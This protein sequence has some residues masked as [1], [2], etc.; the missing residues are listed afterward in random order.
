[1]LP[2]SA[3]KPELPWRLAAEVFQLRLSWKQ[4]ASCMKV[5]HGC[6]GRRTRWRPRCVLISTVPYPWHLVRRCLSASSTP[7]SG[8]TK[9]VRWGADLSVSSLVHALRCQ[10]T[11]TLREF[12]DIFDISYIEATLV[13]GWRH[14]R[15]V[16][17]HREH[18]RWFS[19][20]VLDWP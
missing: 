13:P 11:H 16:A 20:A 1:M 9:V 6:A 14:G 10:V 8:P 3:F 19:V 4:H 2:Y 18:P 7:R 12:V 5:G 17:Y 15:D